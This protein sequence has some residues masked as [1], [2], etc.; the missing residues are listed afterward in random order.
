MVFSLT[1]NQLMMKSEITQ[2][3]SLSQLLLSLRGNKI[4]MSSLDT[5]QRKFSI[6]PKDKYKDKLTQVQLI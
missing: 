5:A 3:A 1:V 4:P 2:P 6:T